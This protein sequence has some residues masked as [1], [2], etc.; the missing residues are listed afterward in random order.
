MR[1]VIQSWIEHFDDSFCHLPKGVHKV[2]TICDLNLFQDLMIIS[3][4]FEILR[5]RSE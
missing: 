5:Y 3:N 1:Q 4:L 2:S